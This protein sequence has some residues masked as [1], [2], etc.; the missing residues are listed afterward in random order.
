MFVDIKSLEDK[1]ELLREEI[2]SLREEL[3]FAAIMAVMAAV[4]QASEGLTEEQL[5]SSVDSLMKKS[6]LLAKAS[7]SIKT[8]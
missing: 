4:A 2:V 1:I 7:D 5:I 6:K 8:D 3:R